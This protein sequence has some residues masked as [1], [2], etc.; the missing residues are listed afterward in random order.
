VFGHRGGIDFALASEHASSSVQIVDVDLHVDPFEI[1]IDTTKG[2]LRD[3]NQAR[4]E[5]LHQEIWK[6]DG[7]NANALEGY[8]GAPPQGYV[9]HAVVPRIFLGGEVDAIPE[10]DKSWA[11]RALKTAIPRAARPS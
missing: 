2:V 7:V 3:M 4:F 6:P 5:T 8:D 11:T 9:S 1:T 10:I